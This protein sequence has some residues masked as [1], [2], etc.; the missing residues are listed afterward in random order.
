MMSRRAVL[1]SATMAAAGGLMGAAPAAMAGGRPR[2]DDEW[3]GA[4]RRLHDSPDEPAVVVAVGRGAELTV[5]T[6]GSSQL[7]TRRT[8]RTEDHMRVASVAKAFSGAAVLALVSSGRLSLDA[9]I[10]RTVRG[11]P[12]QFSDVTL[13]QL[14]GHT[15]GIPDFSGTGEFRDTVVANLLNP[16]PPRELPSFVADADLAFRP[17]SRYEYSNS[18]NIVVGLMCEAVTAAATKTC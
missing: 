13:R 17:G 3:R 10:G 2:V 14:L 7:G 18:D 12:R 8:P 11:L 15:S 4:V 9:T 1:A 6:A 5:Y 16:P